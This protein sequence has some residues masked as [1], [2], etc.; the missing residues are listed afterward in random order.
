MIFDEIAKRP[1]GWSFEI[2]GSYLEIYMERV[3]DLLDPDKVNLDLKEDKKKGVY[4]A[5]LTK[6]SISSLQDVYEVLR[7]GDKIRKVAAT[8]MNAGS[9]RSHSVLSIYLS[10]TDPEGVK[11]V[12]QLNLVD[13]AGSERLSKTEATGDVMKQGALI[14]KSLTTLS[15]VIST[16]SKNSGL[17]ANKQG[18]IPYR[19]STLTRLLQTSLGGNSKTGLSIHL[20]PHIDNLEESI[21]TLDFGSRAKMIKTN[22]KS[23]VQKTVAQLE[24]ELE[25]L[26]KEHDSLKKAFAAMN[27]GKLPEGFFGTSDENAEGEEGGEGGGGDG[28]KG[29]I[30][31]AALQAEKDKVEE[32]ENDKSNL[33]H[34]NENLVAEIANLEEQLQ[35]EVGKVKSL[36]KDLEIKQLE[37]QSLETKVKNLEGGFDETPAEAGAAPAKPGDAKGGK[38]KQSAEVV[39]LNKLISQQRDMLNRERDENREL[40]QENLELNEELTEK[41]RR[42]ALAELQVMRYEQARTKVKDNKIKAKIRPNKAK[43]SMSITATPRIGDITSRTAQ[44]DFEA[45]R[46]ETVLEKFGNLNP[47]PVE[48][49]RGG[50][51][52]FLY[53][54]FQ[55]SDFAKRLFVIRD[56]F[57]ICY[58]NQ[59]T[60]SHEPRYCIPLSSSRISGSCPKQGD[61]EFCFMVL[62][63]QYLIV[64]ATA[65][66]SEKTVWLKEL[67]YAKWVTHETLL[68]F[69]YFNIR[70]VETLENPVE[71]TEMISRIKTS[72]Y[73][74]FADIEYAMATP[75]S[76]GMEG[77]LFTSGFVNASETSKDSVTKE[78]KKFYF[79]IRDSYLLKY[80][81]I[82]HS[83]LI[84]EPQGLMH[85]GTDLDIVKRDEESDETDPSGESRFYFTV[86]QETGANLSLTVYTTSSEERERW[87]KALNMATLVTTRNVMLAALHKERI[88][89]KAGINP[90]GCEFDMFNRPLPPACV[91]PFDERG[92]PLYRHPDG[93]VLN[94][95]LKQVQ[96]FQERYSVDKKPLDFFDRPLPEGAQQ[97]YALN[98]VEPIGVGID[99]LHYA[100]PSGRTFKPT[101]PHFD[102]LSRELP[103]EVVEAAD[104]V[105]PTLRI[106]SIVRSAVLTRQKHPV[107]DAFGRPVRRA[108]DGSLF[109]LEGQQL[110]VTATVFDAFGHKISLPPAPRGAPPRRT[111]EI[112]Y[113]NNTGDDVKVGSVGIEDNHTTLLDLQTVVKKNLDQILGAKS[114]ARVSF[115]LHGV[116]V[117]DAECETRLASEAAPVVYLSCRDMQG[118]RI[119]FDGPPF[120]VEIDHTVLD[121]EIGK[122]KEASFLKLVGSQR[123]KTLV[124]GQ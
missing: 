54:K 64:L 115:L 27:G 3:N 57:L 46:R 45:L 73:A 96:L 75:S 101:D 88:A 81:L 69:A 34:E 100:Y 83:D 16:L 62:C 106:A 50:R 116:M 71:R 26:Q 9:S 4:V 58:D 39:E 82:D 91:Q 117:P 103:P 7:R 98:P 55:N 10:Q 114:L 17:P 104:A 95:D 110:P 51:D 23:M 121:D 78:W 66:E 90:K 24:A 80:D 36:R 52:G 72:P 99:G 31:F 43:P 102:Q 93:R 21:S 120:T 108:R 61:K 67:S 32:L 113:V 28:G 122:D 84:T 11:R 33:K 35:L 49:L 76:G 86:M 19:D 89:V 14:N 5:G 59:D 18:H 65:S 77:F 38:G 70:A 1:D 87:M 119:A 2:D 118:K 92:K 56:S 47:V 41:T 30:S 112:R 20:S 68:E 109:T 111:L 13:L 123:R 48:E 63:G 37:V 22:A 42:L 97:M 79:A 105:V 60:N 29:G 94:K 8:K 53:E 44:V 85:L 6:E 15:L 124:P 40:R 25:K 107:F 12:S 74:P